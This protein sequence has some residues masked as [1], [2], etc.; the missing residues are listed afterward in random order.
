MKARL[1]GAIATAICS[2]LIITWVVA[3][4]EPPPPI[5]P[6]PP[7]DSQS[8]VQQL[9]RAAGGKVRV[10]YHAKTGYARYIGAE[11]GHPISLE[12]TIPAGAGP[13]QV[14]RGFLSTYGR[15]FGLRD[16]ASELAV[17]RIR[18]ADRGRS[19][20]RFQQV[21]QNIP[22]VGGE[23]IVQTGERRSVISVHG[24]LLPEINV[25]VAPRVSAET[26]RQRAIEAVAKYHSLS[27]ADL[28]TTEPE[29]WLYN[30]V[31]LGGPGLQRNT[32]VWR[33][34]V[35]PIRIAPVRE[36]VLVD[37]QLGALALH[38]NQVEAALS[39]RT[40][41]ANNGT[42]LPGTL[43]CDQSN[44]SC[45]GGDSHA[46]AAHRNA[47]ATYD[48]YYAQHWRDSINNAGMTIISTVHYDSG[49]ANAFWNGNQMVYGDAYGFPLADDVVAHELTHGVTDYEAN[50]FYYYQSG[51]INESLSDLWGE[52][53]DLYGVTDNDAGDTR[54]EVGED[55]AG[56]PAY[57]RR[58][59]QDPTLYGQP[60]RIGSSLYACGQTE[61]SLDVGDAGGVHT[62][63]GVNNKAVYLLTDG[64]FFNGYTVDGLGY[65]KVAD[66]Y[67]EV[68]TSLLTSAADYADLYD[69][70][71]Q[72]AVNL[73]F[74]TSE[75][76]QVRNAIDAVEMNQQP[77]IC[78]ADEAPLCPL[79]SECSD[80][81]F[82]D[83]ESSSNWTHGA[84]LGTDYWAIDATYATSG[85]YS[86]WSIDIGETSDTYIALNRDVQV[87]T[88][89]TIYLHF[90]HAF[91][92]EASL[93]GTYRYDGG[94]VEYSTNGGA[95]WNDAI[96]LF[97]YN[98]YNGTLA[99][100]Y[101]NPLAGRQA[102]S[103]DSFGY[104]SS[105][106]NLSPLAG[107]N[108]RFRFR[109]ATD[110]VGWDYGWFID[111]VRI[112]TCQPSSEYKVYVPL[113]MKNFQPPSGWQTIK[114]EDF[115]GTFPGSWVVGDN[116]GASYGEYYWAKRY[117]NPFAGSYSGWAAGGGSSGSALACNSNYPNYADSWMVYGP[118]SL[119]DATAAELS[120]KLWLN[121]ESGYDGIVATASIDGVNFY[122][123]GWTGYSA[124]WIDRTLNL[125]SVPTLGDLAGRSRVWIA[126]IFISDNVYNYPHGAY[127]DN[128]VLRKCTGATCS[129]GATL[130]ADLAGS[131]L[132]AMQVP[133]MKLGEPTQVRE[134]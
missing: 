75:Q 116:N 48:F 103:G 127:I 123:Q 91:G 17:K 122:G 77:V 98:G 79:G 6:T 128:I 130:A 80:L 67:Y 44:P 74:S 49:Y 15:L 51:A 117:C 26:A 10:S 133:M 45:S 93:A 47:A 62:N 16:Q 54:W 3:A 14:A 115:E 35:Q 73:G 111:D 8:L 2:V 38:F 11:P 41:T 37:A 92:F 97:D 104:I 105:R 53:V 99:T 119:A 85:N 132:T 5:A 23:L 40:Y 42:T 69:A 90:K 114:S 125:G 28:V 43:V 31:L 89:G 63:S 86:I 84:L 78:P 100:G 22:V 96:S 126:F 18:S 83:M 82:D 108:V 34:E 102:F 70:L 59:M 27:A 129:G 106:L 7:S 64:G 68:Q 12:G 21:H 109:L 101:G 71:L 58:N 110:T 52:F 25:D 55:I 24:E 60:D 13:E 112:Y 57:Y 66:L 72:A 124:G 121:S 56:A 4:Q 30:S 134:R 33:M 61:P 113:V 81:F 20:V 39:Q 107:Q 1:F 32:L 76:Q 88:T 19:F 94:V 9:Q 46:V 50:L 65:A 36:F 29:L 118:F 87:P 95:S 131:N 120:Y